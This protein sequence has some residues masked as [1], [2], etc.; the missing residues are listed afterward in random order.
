[1]S[2]VGIEKIATWPSTLTLSMADLCAARP[3]LDPAHVRGALLADARTVLPP[4]EDT[5]TLAVNAAER[6]LTPDDRARVGLLVAATETSLDREKPI[7]TWVH[8]HLGLPSRCRNFEVKHACYSATAALRMA[9]GWLRGQPD[10]AAALV[11]SADHSLLGLGQPYE[12]VNGA[13]AVALLV[14]RRPDVLIL[15]P[16]AGVFAAEEHGVVRPT[17]RVETGN[18]AASLYAYVDAL[19]GALAD[20]EDTVG[21]FEPGAFAGCIYHTPFAGMGRRAH[22]VALQRSGAPDRSALDAA[23]E[24]QVLPGLRHLRRIGGTY[25]ASTFIA[26]QTHAERLEPQDRVSLFA[27]GS[28]CCAELYTGRIGAGARRR[29]EAADLGGLLDARE[30]LDVDT[31]RALERA[32]DAAW[33][34]A[35][36][37]PDH[38]PVT[39]HFERCWAGSGRLYLEGVSGYERRYR[40]A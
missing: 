13:G 40:R 7:S 27:Y 19:D 14:S 31:Y 4:W 25:G 36:F 11:V 38:G 23:F 24:R 6:A 20:Y 16:G 29:A 3:A 35:D 30:A 21:P 18:A 12:P 32:R 5:V 39:G 26:L 10:E 9:E 37:A 15:E 22:R 1:M 8:R 33:G 17:A 34:Q 28:G 2:G